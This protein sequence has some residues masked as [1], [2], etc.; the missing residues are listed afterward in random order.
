MGYTPDPAI[1]E[2]EAILGKL[3]LEGYVELD[4]ITE[5]GYLTY[6]LTEKGEQIARELI[7]ES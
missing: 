5:E 4:G 6:R 2:V 1:D 7:H 3:V